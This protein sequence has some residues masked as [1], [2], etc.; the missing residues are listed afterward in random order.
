MSDEEKIESE[1]EVVG[2]PEVSHISTVLVIVPPESYAEETL[3]YTRSCLA[4]VH[5]GTRTVST[6]DEDLIEGRLQDSFQPDAPLAG[7]SM[8]EYSG[9]VLV[10]GEGSRSMA[11]NSDVQRLVREASGAGKLLGAWAESVGSLV[12]AGVVRGRKLTGARNLAAQIQS[13]G[14]KYTGVQVERDGSLVTGL[15]DAAGIRFARALAQVV[16]I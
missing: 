13:A 8:G 9:L 14:G 10:A 1:A 7:Q 5:V 16:G 11:A 4:N 15:D 3:R 12:S 2:P 6:V